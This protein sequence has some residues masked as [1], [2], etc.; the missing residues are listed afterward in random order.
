MNDRMSDPTWRSGNRSRG[1]VRRA[2][3]V[4]LLLA[5]PCAVAQDFGHHTGLAEASAAGPLDA[6]H[7]VVA[8]DECN[9]LLVYKFGRPAP[10]GKPIDLAG[11]LGTKDKASDLE[12]AARVGNLIYWISSHSLTKSGKA[13]QWRHRFFATSVDRTRSPPTVTPFGIPYAG[14]AKAAAA[15]T[16]LADLKLEDAAAI[17]PEE[18]GGLN[19]EGLAAWKSDGL[20]IGFRSPL[21][22]GNK[23]LLVPLENPSAVVAG[24][25]PRFASAILLDLGKRGIRSIDR[26]GDHY[27]I[28]AGPTGNTGSFDLYRWSGGATDKPVLLPA[29]LPAGHAFE[30]LVSIPGTKGKK[31]VL[32][33]DDGADDDIK[34]GK[35]GKAGQKFRSLGI[36]LQ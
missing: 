3:P 27:I 9:T 15:E 17:P 6:Q 26:V 20:L 7:M 13:N 29:S 18:P 2:T 16:R 35:P 23:A 5:L 21:R 8:E 36:E 33:S 30:A 10:V 19:I 1:R 12:G 34:C 25:P 22:D 24:E 4:V 32:L 11:F 28:V 31:A 14:L